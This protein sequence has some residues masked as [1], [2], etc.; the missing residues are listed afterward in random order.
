MD[1]G[2]YVR[3]GCTDSISGK[4]Q[5]QASLGVNRIKAGE[6]NNKRKNLG[7]LAWLSGHKH[8][9]G[10]HDMRAIALRM[11][12]RKGGRIRTNKISFF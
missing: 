4:G 5:I 11:E 6:W 7:L 2:I 1:I 9:I 3:L 8:F 10:V 12:R